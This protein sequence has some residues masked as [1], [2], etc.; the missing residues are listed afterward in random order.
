MDNK[1][2]ENKYGPKRKSKG[3]VFKVT[4]LNEKRLKALVD[5]FKK[6]RRR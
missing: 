4:I 3:F 5:F 1:P 6:L 2:W